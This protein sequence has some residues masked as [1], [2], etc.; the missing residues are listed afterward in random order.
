MAGNTP[1]YP[2]V[3]VALVGEDGNAF[4]ILGRVSAAMR[5][6][7]VASGQIEMFRA[8]AMSGDYDHLLRTCMEWVTVE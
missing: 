2:H 7:G 5:K 6:A 8:E 1:R 3:E 4:F